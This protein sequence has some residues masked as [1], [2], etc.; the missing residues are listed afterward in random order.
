M[1][2]F[3][4][5]LLSVFFS[6]LMH[7]QSDS[8]ATLRQTSVQGN[9]QID[10]EINSDNALIVTP[11]NN[12]IQSISNVLFGACVNIS[13]IQ[14][15]YHPNSI[16]FF[17][18]TTGYL[19]IDSGL[20]MTT[21][22][23][24]IAAMPNYAGNMGNNNNVPGHP[25]LNQ[26]IANTTFDACF[27]SFD[28]T[29]Q[30]DTIIACTF[31]FGSEEYPEWVWTGYNDVFAFFISGPGIDGDVGPYK[32]LARLPNASQTIM[33]IDSINHFNNSSY[34]F[35]NDFS[36]SPMALHF[37][38]DGFVNVVT[39]QHPVI[40]GETYSFIIAIADARDAIYDSGVF[41]KAGSF[42][43]NQPLPAAKFSSVQTN[44]YTVQF[45]NESIGAKFYEWD[46]GDGNTS[47]EINP[48]FTF[49][50]SGTYPVKLKCS[51]ICYFDV[52]TTINVVVEQATGIQELDPYVKLKTLESGRY[53]L[54][55]SQA[56]QHELF[57]FTISD[58]Q[59]RLLQ[60]ELLNSQ[61][62]LQK[63][64]D[65][66]A[67]DHSMYIIRIYNNKFQWHGKLMR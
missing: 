48:A 37:Q 16:G 17:R 2:K 29:P 43:G 26:M 9:F 21:G 59:G 51:N 63:Q 12:I 27:I 20:V 50:G 8:L 32:N 11:L 36:T 25:L 49:D 19:G 6:L 39:L 1:N 30:A 65:L 18:D 55:L 13:N 28:F 46:F 5:I 56:F 38:Y 22:A 42:L 7:A 23:I 3:Y 33:S 41:L 47:E 62:L 61:Q 14:F 35:V 60:S 4:Y 44:G 58:L 15:G 57:S 67:F 66:Q 34:Y 54:E 24:Q 64:I 31:R 45:I 52:D 10:E 40:P 53:Q